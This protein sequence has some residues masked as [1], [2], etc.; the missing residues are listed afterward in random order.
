MFSDH[1]E[2]KL[3]IT[4]NKLI[5][6]SQILDINNIFRLLLKQCSQESL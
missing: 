2:I 4:N 3:E 1:K 6:K 5:N